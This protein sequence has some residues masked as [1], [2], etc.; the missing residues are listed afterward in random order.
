MEMGV[1][2]EEMFGM[3]GHLRPPFGAKEGGV[4]ANAET[5][6]Q[7]QGA[8]GHGHGKKFEIIVNGRPKTV[9]DHRVSFEQVVRLAFDPVPAGPNVVITVSYRHAD[10]RPEQG[11][12]IAGQSVKVKDGTVF[13]VSATDKS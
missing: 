6:E 1:V 2:Y 13:N 5:L 8:A 4:M 11:T 7:E 10:Q 12:L 3:S 9:E